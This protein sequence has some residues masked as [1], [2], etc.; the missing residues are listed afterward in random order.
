MSLGLF[1]AA[2]II[3]YR[4]TPSYKY[5][6][7]KTSTK[8]ILSAA[9]YYIDKSGWEFVMKGVTEDRESISFE[10]NNSDTLKHIIFSTSKN[11]AIDIIRYTKRYR[12]NSTF[13]F[14]RM[15]SKDTLVSYYVCSSDTIFQRGEYLNR[16]S[17][18]KLDTAERKFYLL[19][20]D[21]LKI[22]RGDNLPKLPL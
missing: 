13:C 9:P 17:E 10:K 6:F 15:D 16:F 2:G 1:I 5:F 3:T 20:R 12:K 18:L 19:H 4:I 8:E 7:F 14:L 11:D 21:S 22:I